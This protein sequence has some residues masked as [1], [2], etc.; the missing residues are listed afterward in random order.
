[1]PSD[2]RYVPLDPAGARPD[3]HGGGEILPLGEVAE[4]LRIPKK[5]A[6]QIAR[7]GELRAF[8]AGRHWRVHRAELGAWIAR[9]SESGNGV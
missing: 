8:K 6:Y 7:S 1:M 9:Q 5:T 4:Y 2:V 3:A